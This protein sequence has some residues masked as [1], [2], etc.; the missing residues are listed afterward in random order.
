MAWW[1]G[2]LPWELGSGRELATCGTCNA[3]VSKWSISWCTLSSN[4]CILGNIFSLTWWSKSLRRVNVP[5][6]C[7]KRGRM[8]VWMKFSISTILCS[9]T[10]PL[11][12]EVG[13]ALGDWASMVRA[14]FLKSSFSALSDSTM[15]LKLL[16]SKSIADSR[17]WATAWVA[18]ARTTASEVWALAAATALVASVTTAETAW[19][20][21]ALTSEVAA[22]AAK[23]P[24]TEGSGLKM[25]CWKWIDLWSMF[26]SLWSTWYAWYCC[27]SGSLWDPSAWIL[28]TYD[29]SSKGGKD[30]PDGEIADSSSAF[31]EITC[32]LLDVVGSFGTGGVCGFAGN[33][34]LTWVRFLCGWD[35]GLER[36]EAPLD[37]SLDRF[38]V[39]P[40]I[41]AATPPL[42]SVD[43][44]KLDDSPDSCIQVSRTAAA[45]L[46]TGTPARKQGYPVLKMPGHWEA[47]TLGT[48]LNLAIASKAATMSFTTTRSGGGLR[49]LG[50]KQM[51]GTPLSLSWRQISTLSSTCTETSC[52]WMSDLSLSVV[53]PIRRSALWAVLNRRTDA[54]AWSLRNLLSAPL[55]PI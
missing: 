41:P 40:G 49:R 25:L 44:W 13:S 33:A 6:R 55:R 1:T 20:A 28:G 17:A 54:K 23:C 32:V 39:S 9:I 47:Q 16:S 12:L 27:I 26:S 50:F 45:Q 29:M 18:S 3:F 52:A 38:P 15:A 37:D 48:S 24:T 35:F 53:I 46:P 22:V 8:P 31:M 5:S 43:N 34:F 4:P 36:E 51:F 21:S 19:V 11:R 42:L 7:V 2:E 14:L 30:D 10:A